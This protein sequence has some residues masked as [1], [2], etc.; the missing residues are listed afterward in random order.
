VL[1]VLTIGSMMV[2]TMIAGAVLVETV[3]SLPG[4]G[5][6]L[7]TGIKQYNYPVTQIL[8]LILL[9]VFL[10][11]STLVDILYAVIDPRIKLQ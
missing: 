8:L 6:L 10:V 5:S 7:I 3:F 2:G 9:A 1:P 11:I 4:M